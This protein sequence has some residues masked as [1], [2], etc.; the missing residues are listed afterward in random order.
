M[1]V[2]CIPI[3]IN[4]YQY[5]LYTGE[6]IPIQS[7]THKFTAVAICVVMGKQFVIIME[8]YMLINMLLLQDCILLI[9]TLHLFLY[10]VCEQYLVQLKHFYKKP[11]ANGV[12]EAILSRQAQFLD[13][14]ML[15]VGHLAFVELAVG[16]MGVAEC[17]REE[18]KGMS[19]GKGR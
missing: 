16:G 19:G 11:G 9:G 14:E 13:G 18:R 1:G 8:K 5:T 4:T 15:D 6:S 7:V 12:Q 3:C 17:Q 2:I 10:S